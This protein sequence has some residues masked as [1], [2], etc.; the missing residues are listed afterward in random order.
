MSK[1]T[2]PIADFRLPSRSIR[3]GLKTIFGIVTA[4]SIALAWWY[5]YRAT[6]VLV[7]QV[8]GIIQAPEIAS[9]TGTRTVHSINGSPYCWIELTAEDLSQVI[10]SSPPVL[11]KAIDS[12][13]SIHMW[14]VQANAHTYAKTLPIDSR[15]TG[16][17]PPI[18]SIGDW[19]TLFLGV[20]RAGTQQQLRI[21]GN[22][23]HQVTVVNDKPSLQYHNAK[24][25]GTLKYEGAFP[26]G[27]ILFF[28]PQDGNAYHVVIFAAA[29]TIPPTVNA[30][31][32]AEIQSSGP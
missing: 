17:P 24:A 1:L 10:E 15:L 12:T 3:F 9:L 7:R 4:A 22:V 19:T 30:Q 31:N 23:G 16:T 25:R 8:S 2:P 28:A 21:D 11:D 14:P 32:K 6:T 18:I 13:D 29:S 27:A 5:Y 26:H 20:R